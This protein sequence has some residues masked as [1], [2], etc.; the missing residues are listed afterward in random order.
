MELSS[1]DSSQYRSQ[2]GRRLSH[3]CRICDC[4]TR[5]NTPAIG[6]QFAWEGWRFRIVDMDGSRISKVLASRD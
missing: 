6:D 4:S 5:Q 2:A 1:S 3:A